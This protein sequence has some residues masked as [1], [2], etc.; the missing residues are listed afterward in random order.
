[1]SADKDIF[2]TEAL[3]P[4][5]FEVRLFTGSFIVI[6]CPIKSE[7]EDFGSIFFKPASILVRNW[8]M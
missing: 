7:D 3:K 2:P 5:G 1:M 8:R 4:E 6:C